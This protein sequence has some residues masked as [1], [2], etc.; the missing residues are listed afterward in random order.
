MKNNRDNIIA[1]LVKEEKAFRQ[2]LRKGLRQMQRY[3]DD[4]LDW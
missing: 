2:T 1:V 3:I 4:W